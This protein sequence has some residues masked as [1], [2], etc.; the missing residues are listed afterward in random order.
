MLSE[1][2]QEKRSAFDELKNRISGFLASHGVEDGAALMSTHINAEQASVAIAAR[3]PGLRK[4]WDDA[5]SAREEGKRLVEYHV[6]LRNAQDSLRQHLAV[7]PEIEE[8]VEIE[9]ALRAEPL[10]SSLAE[11]EGRRTTCPCTTAGH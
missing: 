7:Q 6:E 8:N 3:L 11:I 4:Q 5:R 9:V 1:M 10:R 2:T